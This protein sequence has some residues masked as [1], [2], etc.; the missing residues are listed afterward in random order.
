MTLNMN[1]DSQ[2][3][4]DFKCDR[5]QNLLRKLLT[6]QKPISGRGVSL[7][8]GGSYFDDDYDVLS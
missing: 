3:K 2:T 7:M 6:S 5:I 4:S 1:H 8:L